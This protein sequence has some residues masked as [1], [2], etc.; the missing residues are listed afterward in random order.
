VVGARS[1][2]SLVSTGGGRSGEREGVVSV[3]ADVGVGERLVERSGDAVGS[4]REG[5]G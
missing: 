1:V 2:E 3:R 5:V 4:M